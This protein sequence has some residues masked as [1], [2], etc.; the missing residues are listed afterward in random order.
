MR[1]KFLGLIVLLLVPLFTYA[2]NDFTLT[3]NLQLKKPKLCSTNWG[4]YVNANFD[5]LD[6]AIGSIKGG[7]VDLPYNPTLTYDLATGNTFVTVLNGAVTS[8]TV[9]GTPTIGQFIYLIT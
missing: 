7:Y 5:S 4:T 2:Q 3:P 9:A 6:S 1:M 8:S